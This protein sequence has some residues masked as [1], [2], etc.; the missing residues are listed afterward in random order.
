MYSFSCEHNC[1]LCIRRASNIIHKCKEQWKKQL[2][3]KWK[4][5]SSLILLIFLQTSL[6]PRKLEKWPKNFGMLIWAR[7]QFSWDLNCKMMW[8]FLEPTTWLNSN[9]LL[10]PQQTTFLIL[11]ISKFG[12]FVPKNKIIATEYSLLKILIFVFGRN[13]MC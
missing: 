3:N 7:V 6:T 2:R 9:R 12:E 5:Q 1:V 4:K 13:F 11:N 8:A 10:P